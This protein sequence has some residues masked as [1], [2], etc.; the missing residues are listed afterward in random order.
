MTFI[1]ALSLEVWNNVA[2]LAGQKY[3]FFEGRRPLRNLLTLEERLH[4][5]LCG[6]AAAATAAPHR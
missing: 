2:S 5:R 1:I 3:V 4:R 6:I